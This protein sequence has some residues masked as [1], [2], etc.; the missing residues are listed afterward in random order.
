MIYLSVTVFV[1]SVIGAFAAGAY[2]WP[3][4]TQMKSEIVDALTP[5]PQVVETV[6]VREAPP[7]E[8]SYREM[9]DR[10]PLDAEERRELLSYI[11]REERDV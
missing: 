9:V 5:T 1:L 11:D 2:F 7:P 3:K 8:L 4:A 6:V 10:L